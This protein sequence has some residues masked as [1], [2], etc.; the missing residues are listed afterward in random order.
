[1]GGKR[2]SAGPKQGGSIPDFSEFELSVPEVK[3]AKPQQP[4]SSL[5]DD[6]RWVYA[7][8][9]R[10]IHHSEAP[11][12]GAAELLAQA[13]QDRRW[14]LDK[15]LPK[16]APSKAEQAALES[17]RDDSSRQAELISRARKAIESAAGV[18]GG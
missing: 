17:E 16:I 12:R 5:V 9:G 3:P 11:S 18:Y 1:M 7:H 2:S 14:F 10:E 4:A 8:L 6:V 15:M 13:N